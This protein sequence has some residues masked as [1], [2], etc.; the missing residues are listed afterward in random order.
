MGTEVTQVL[1]GRFR[2]IDGQDSYFIVRIFIQFKQTWCSETIRTAL[3][4]GILRF[5]YTT[6]SKQ[7]G[8]LLMAQFPR[9]IY[10]CRYCP[11]IAIHFKNFHKL[12]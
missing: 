4:I 11:Y 3:L 10:L 8:Q 6:N 12:L 7:D 1:R 5:G 9:S 2:T